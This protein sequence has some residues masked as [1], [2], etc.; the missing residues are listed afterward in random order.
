M[1]TNAQAA[2]IAAASYCSDENWAPDAVLEQAAKFKNALDL[3]DA[4]DRPRKGTPKMT[5]RGSE[6]AVAHPD[7]DRY[8]V[9]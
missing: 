6:T 2:L 9:N 7:E 5:P 4:A 8:L 3:Q 1:M